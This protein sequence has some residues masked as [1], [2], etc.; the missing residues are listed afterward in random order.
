MGSDTRTVIL[1]ERREWALQTF[2]THRSTSNV[3]RPT[4]ASDPV[5]QSTF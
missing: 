3:Q 5:N 1:E 4:L 2:A